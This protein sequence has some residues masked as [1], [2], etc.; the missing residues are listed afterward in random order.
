[1]SPELLQIFW[2]FSIFIVLLFA[3]GLYCM[4]ATFNLIRALIGLELLLKAVTLLIILVGYV[5]GNS[6]MTQALVI[7][8]I[9]IEVVVMTV[10]VGVVLGIR[11]Y[12]NSLDVR[13]I[14]D[15]K[16]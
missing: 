8:F 9:V 14:K 16:G 1:M 15:I 5:T 2:P 6:V 11:S 3:V 13:K 7:T 10:A 12:N 4:L